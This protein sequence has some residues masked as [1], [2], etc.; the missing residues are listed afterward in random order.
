MVKFSKIQ[1]SISKY[2][3]V[4]NISSDNIKNTI[5]GIVNLSKF[6]CL[7]ELYCSNN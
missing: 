7:K 2:A 4:I 1:K 6:I 3:T 5:K